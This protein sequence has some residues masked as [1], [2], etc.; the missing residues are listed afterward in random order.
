MKGEGEG[1][2]LWYVRGYQRRSRGAALRDLTTMY[3]RAARA[4]GKAVCP[5]LERVSAKDEDHDYWRARAVLVLPASA[6]P[7]EWECLVF[8]ERES[9]TAEQRIG[10]SVQGAVWRRA[11]RVA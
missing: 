10:A 7:R 5:A 9:G 2:A 4:D 8:V 6:D 3:K 11:R 1:S